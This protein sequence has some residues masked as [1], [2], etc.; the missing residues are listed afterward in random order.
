[1][2]K[3]EKIIF[4]FTMDTMETYQNV[5]TLHENTSLIH[6]VHMKSVLNGSILLDGDGCSHMFVSR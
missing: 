1:M 5:V 6:Q 4:Y 3:E 2:M